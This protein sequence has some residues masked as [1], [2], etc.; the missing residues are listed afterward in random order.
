MDKKKERELAARAVELGESGQAEAVPEL[1][2]LVGHPSVQVR[3]LAASAL[4]KL[5]GVAEAASV[6]SALTARLRDPHPQVRQYAIKAL[7]AYGAAAEPALPDLQDLVDRPTEKDYN[8][9]D[10]AKALATLREA[11]RIALEEAQVRCQRCARILTADE[12][13]RAMRAFQRPYCDTCFNEVFLRRRNYDTQVE[14]NKTIPTADG[15]WVQSEGERIIADFLTQ[16]HIAYRYDERLQII[17]GYAIRPDFYLPEFDVY[18]E[19]W[20]MDTIDYQIGMLKKQ[21]LYQQQGKRLI[22][23]HFRDKP[24]LVQVLAEKLS[25]Y[26]RL[27]PGNADEA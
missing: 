6:V 15:R 18:I 1:L 11:R 21:K 23:L 16:H 7:S 10:A 4:G 5:A 19:Y 20:G 14:L 2:T 22:S 26:M 9:R 13:A 12:Y 3:R 27:D 24:H 8:R 17:D 25:R